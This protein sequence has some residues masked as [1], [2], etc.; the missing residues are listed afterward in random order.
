MNTRPL[1]R[2]ISIIIATP[3]LIFIYCLSMSI[4]IRAGNICII[5]IV[6]ITIIIHHLSSI[7]T[8]RVNRTQHVKVLVHKRCW[9]KRFYLL[10]LSS[11]NLRSIRIYYIVFVIFI[12][13]TAGNVLFT[14]FY[15]S[16]ER[17]IFTIKIIDKFPGHV[18]I[19]LIVIAVVIAIVIDT[20]FLYQVYERTFFWLSFLW[21]MFG[22]FLNN[23]IVVVS[24]LYCVYAV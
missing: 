22:I 8:N 16:V 6:S 20:L 4:H 14:I 18:K 10:F 2:T 7:Q 13:H 23:N 1:N 19:K 21:V 5:I 11:I 17:L 15:L 9:I 3:Q 12:V 24:W